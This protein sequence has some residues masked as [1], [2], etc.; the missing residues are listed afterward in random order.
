MSKIIAEKNKT[1]IVKLLRFFWGDFS[2]YVPDAVNLFCQEIKRCCGTLLRYILTQ[3]LKK[4]RKKYLCEFFTKNAYTCTWRPLF[5]N[6]KFSCFFFIF[7]FILKFGICQVSS[8]VYENFLKLP[9][10]RKKLIMNPPNSNPYNNTDFVFLI[11]YFIWELLIL[12]AH[13]IFSAKKETRIKLTNFTLYI[14]KS[15]YI[16]LNSTSNLNVS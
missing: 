6:D 14:F 9:A 15:L 3:P 11:L 7:S 4:E 2:Q 13:S 10:P 12:S 8:V 1:K 16:I 5:Y